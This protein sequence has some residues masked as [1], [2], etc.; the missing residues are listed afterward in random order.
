MN[1]IEPSSVRVRSRKSLNWVPLSG[2]RLNWVQLSGSRLNWVQ[3][4]GSRLN[5]VQLSGSP[6]ISWNQCV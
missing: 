6:Y 5:W 1:P 4:S 2:S 3:L